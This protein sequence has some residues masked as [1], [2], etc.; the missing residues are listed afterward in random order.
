M[1][2]HDLIKCKYDGGFLPECE[3]DNKHD[4][5]KGNLSTL[6]IVHSTKIQVLGVP[7]RQFLPFLKIA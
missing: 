2:I 6:S 7:V 1:A 3:V 5:I 4:N